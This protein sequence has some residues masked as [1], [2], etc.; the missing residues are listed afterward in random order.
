M[1]RTEAYHITHVIIDMVEAVIAGKKDSLFSSGS[2]DMHLA[3]E[4]LVKAF[5]N[6]VR[7]RGD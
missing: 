6:L 3:E 7:G 5:S 2:T 1:Q 4:D